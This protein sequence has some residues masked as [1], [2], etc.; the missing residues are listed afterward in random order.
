LLQSIE[1]GGNQ[2]K[3]SEGIALALLAATFYGF[4]GVAFELAAK[5]EYPSWDFMMYKQLCGTLLGLAMALALRLP[6]LEPRVLVLALVGA[7]FYLAT[8]WAYLT[9]SRE[10]DIAANWTILNLSVVVPVCLSVF[11]FHDKFSS[12][13]AV[14]FGFTV[15]AIVLIGGLGAKK[16]D[17]TRK[18][19]RWITVAFL[20][21][22]WFVI[23]LRFVPE[24][25]GA[26]F[27]FYF[28]GLSTLMTLLYKVIVREDFSNQQGIY[29]VAALGAVTHWSGIMLTI[30]A[31]YL[32]GQVSAR[33]GLIVYPITNGLPIVTG[34][35]IGSFVLRQ[36]IAR[37]EQWGIA[38]GV[39][40]MVLLSSG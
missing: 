37:R 38:C 13:K 2:H 40:A 4:L 10:R 17:F 12:S 27:T 7:V 35:V 22:G 3:M 23:L 11:Q 8:L 25:L 33:A 28:Y 19:V 36:K 24:R 21:N 34:V 29:W 18:W 39:V 20:L 6:F 9:A 14:G 16:V 32:V 1:F 5:R 31:L 26:L 30:V 15:L